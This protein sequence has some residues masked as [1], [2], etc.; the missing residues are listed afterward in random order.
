MGFETLICIFECG[1][2]IIMKPSL[3]DLKHFTEHSF[4]CPASYHE[5][6]P[7]GFETTLSIPF[8]FST[9]YHEAIPMGFE[10]L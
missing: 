4:Q 6:I 5:A 8:K 2:C 7:M 9:L 10:T 1:Q 3:W